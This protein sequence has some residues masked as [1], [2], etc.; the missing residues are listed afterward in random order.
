MA[1]DF[2]DIKEF[3]L[4]SLFVAGSGKRSH[5]SIIVFTTLLCD[6]ECDSVVAWTEESQEVGILFPVD[7]G[8]VCGRETMAPT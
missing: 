5:A 3:A 7:H 4:I 6:G 1:F 8:I 2:V